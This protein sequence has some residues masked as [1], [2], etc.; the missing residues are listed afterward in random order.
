M[1]FKNSKKKGQAAIEFL[2][3]YGWMLLI[4]LIVGALVFSFVD[5]GSLL[6]NKLELSGNLRADSSQILASAN[7]EKITLVF[8]YMGAKASYIDP[9]DVEFKSDL[10]WTCD[11]STDGALNITNLDT[12]DY[13]NS[14]GN[15]VNFINGQLGKMEFDCISGSGT[16]SFIEGDVLEGEVL[17]G[18]VNTRTKMEI[19]SNGR[20]RTAVGE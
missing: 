18:V 13:A 10:G 14:T 5:F 7:D 16:P 11:S 9:S 19:P 2:M 12:G 6:P 17:V 1:V 20:L 3:T 15:V 8:T 4:V